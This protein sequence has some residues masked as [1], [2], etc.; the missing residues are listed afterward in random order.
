M[1]AHTGESAA[2]GSR[3]NGQP[4]S[5]VP[6]ASGDLADD[7]DQHHAE[8]RDAEE[9]DSPGAALRARREAL[10]LTI[11]QAAEALHLDPAMVAAIEAD[12]FAALGAPV[13]ARGHLR[14]Y[15]IVLGLSPEWAIERYEALADVPV[16]LS[17]PASG[18]QWRERS[19]SKLPLWITLALLAAGVS[20]GVY[21]LYQE[22]HPG[23]Q[24]VAA[25]TSSEILDELTGAAPGGVPP[26]ALSLVPEEISAVS[27]ENSA[28]AASRASGN[29]PQEPVAPAVADASPPGERSGITEVRSETRPPAAPGTVG[30]SAARAAPAMRLRL[31]F[32]GTSWTEVYD[33]AGKQLVFGMGTAEKVYEAAGVPPL[34][35]ILGYASAV[36]VQVDGQAIVI[37]RRAGRNTARFIIAADGSPVEAELSDE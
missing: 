23:G 32:S 9:S 22:R 25:K 26:S 8:R 36:N 3:M 5:G 19:A 30:A 2:P 7:P 21:G 28:S 6:G 31:A 29:A 15:A 37:P 17:A 11:Q 1:N 35:V 4:V 13:Y 16:P 34:R 33:A 18:L 20:W 14:K 24:D 12:R 27:E 10:G